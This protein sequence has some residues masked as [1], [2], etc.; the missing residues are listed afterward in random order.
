MAT[1]KDIARKCSTSV[2]TVSYVLNGRSLEKRISP[3]TQKKI[4]VAAQELGYRNSS[5]MPLPRSPKIAIF[6]PQKSV[7]TMLPAVINGLNSAL[8]REPIPVDMLICPYESNLLFKQESLWAPKSFDAAIIVSANS[9]DMKA[10]SQ[11]HTEIPVVIHNRV[12]AGYSYVSV[13]HWEAGRLTAIQA[14]CKGG[15]E[16]VLV[17]NPLSFA[18]M[19]LRGKGFCDTCKKY[20]VEMA[21]RILYCGNGIDEGYELGLKLA[22]SGNLP[23]VIACMYDLVGYGLI[24]GLVESGVFVGDEVQVL[25]TSFSFSQFFAKCTPPMTVVDL[26]IEETTERAVRLAIDLASQRLSIPSDIIIPPQ[27]IYRDS[28]PFPTSSELAV[29]EQRHR[30]FR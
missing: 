4:L 11:R 2:A 3:A 8:L 17:L 6:W 14:I 21:D 30:K 12:L 13:D 23:K 27:M 24:R 18:G 19:N 10:L 1:L 20:G 9:A 15:D 28:S 29:L 25:V 22:R 26:Q 5:S 16:I 7:E